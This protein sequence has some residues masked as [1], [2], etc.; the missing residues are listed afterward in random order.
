MDLEKE[1]SLLRNIC[2]GLKL[3]ADNMWERCHKENEKDG[4]VSSSKVSK[5]E[6]LKT[7]FKRRKVSSTVDEEEN[8]KSQNGHYSWTSEG[9]EQL[10]LEALEEAE[11]QLAGQTQVQPTQPVLSKSVSKRV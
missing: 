1:L 10:L 2:G 3:H 4:I 8:K 7:E 5:E 11:K 6:D 9:T